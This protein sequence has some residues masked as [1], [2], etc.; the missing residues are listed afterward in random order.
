MAK[1]SPSTLY[2]QKKG[3]PVLKEEFVD[4]IKELNYNLVAEM[5][6]NLICSWAPDISA[7]L[8]SKNGDFETAT[9]TKT[10]ERK[11]NCF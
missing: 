1:G 2:A 6:K 8:K 4:E 9:E 7:W 10:V 3:I 5:T 11:G